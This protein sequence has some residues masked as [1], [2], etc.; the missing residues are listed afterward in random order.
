[1][2]RIRTIKP[3]F[4]LDEKLGAIQRDAR[5]LYIGLWN[6][7]DDQGVFEWRPARI[8]IQIFPYDIDVND[9]LIEQ[10]LT[11]LVNTGDIIKF[12][13]N[14]S[15]FGFIPTFIKHQDIKNPSQ[16]K[17]ADIPKELLSSHPPLGEELGSDMDGVGDV[18]PS[19][20]PR[21]KESS[22][23]NRLKGIGNREK[24]S[25]IAITFGKIQDD[26]KK[27][28]NDIDFDEEL[29]SCV[30]WWAESRKIL[31]RPKLA[32]RN[33]M[34]NARR[35]KKEHENGAYKGNDKSYGESRR[36]YSQSSKPKDYTGGKYGRAVI[37]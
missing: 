18:L 8:K 26:I 9:G 23:G 25:S 29:K 21:E 12:N 2:P 13:Y 14:S 11:L 4:W 31:K 27:D 16:W 1:M 36:N 10:W 20:T 35:Y 6:L 22:I 17:F 33:W 32:L 3:Q 5:L 7:S 15:T 30:I 28:F 34:L 37:T 24:E 19:P